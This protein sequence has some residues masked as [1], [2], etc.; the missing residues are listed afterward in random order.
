MATC[1][2]FRCFLEGY[3]GDGE[4]VYRIPLSRFPALI[5][6]DDGLAVTLH[7]HNVSRRHAELLQADGELLLRDLGSRNGTYL[8]HE[9]LA[10]AEIVAHGD[11]LRFGDIEFRLQIERDDSADDFTATEFF[12][13]STSID[14]MPIGAQKLEELLRQQLINPHYQPFISTADERIKGLELL[15]RGSHEGLPLAPVP[16]FELALSVGRAV[17]LSELI[18]D[19]GVRAWARARLADVPLFVNTHPLELRNWRRLVASLQS[20]RDEFPDTALVLEIHEQAVTDQGTLLALDTALKQLRIGLAYDDFGAG[21]A[22][23]LE[24]MDVPP[25]TVKFD[26]ALIHDIDKASRQRRDMIGL[27]IALVKRGETA[28]LAEGVSHSGEL[29][30]CRELGFDLIQGFVYGRPLQLAE[31][32]ASRQW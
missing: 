28:A 3:L 10:R 22:R 12:N 29:S 18:R 8:N 17:E 6:R 24:L 14:R 25:S 23:L 13:P 30:A 31:L 26:I 15:G 5:G 9:R 32:A 11:V 4:S 27:L 16:L 2:A 1:A 19:V 7:S 20:L 21:Q